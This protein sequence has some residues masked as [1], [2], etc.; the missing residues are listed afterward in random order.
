MKKTALFLLS[1]GLLAFIV[2]PASSQNAATTTQAKKDVQKNQ[3]SQVTQKAA[4][5]VVKPATATT[6]PV[7]NP[8]GTVQQANPVTPSQ[9]APAV[10][11]P[12]PPVPLTCTWDIVDYDFGKN[13]TQLKP[14]SATFNVTNAGKD[15]V[16]ITLVQ[17]SC[18]CT[19]PKYTKE[20]IKPGEKGE[21]VLT[22]DAKIS[23]FFSK[24]A[25]VKMNDG[26]KY[27]LTIRGEVQKVEQTP[28]T[29]P[30][31][32]PPVIK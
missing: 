21:V 6:A 27:A 2:L 26:Q 31:A 3:Q 29:T 25:V 7:Q 18:G 8:T 20:P 15:P 22:Y 10:T 28:V 1:I 30:P 5:Q 13:V 9:G 17:P 4:N 24:S 16:T 11:P 14:A 12:A 32:T 19:S 23:G